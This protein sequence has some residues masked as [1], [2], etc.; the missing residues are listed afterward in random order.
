MIDAHLHLWR[1]DRGDYD[2]LRDEDPALRRDATLQEWT[3]LAAPLGVDGAVL[4]QAAPTAAETAYVLD[5]AASDPTRLLGVVGWCDLEAPRAAARIRDGEPSALVAL[6]P[7]LQAIDDPDWV[8]SPAVMSALA[9]MQERGL[10]WEAL[11]RPVH[12][13]RVLAVARRLPGLSIVV[14][15]GAKPDIAGGGSTGWAADLADLAACPNV[16][17]KVSGLLTEARPD[18]DREDLRPYVETILAAFGPTR[19]MWGSDWPVVTTRAGYQDWW[20]TAREL[21]PVAWHADVF[22]A[23]ARQAYGL[24][25]PTTGGRS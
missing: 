4:V 22:D 23:T 8:L 13:P 21:V 18:Q 2:W 3:D 10:V 25:V 16:Y 17:C 12:L 1:L 20:E 24:R 19:V 7:W 6:R 14:D 11:V 9:A 15:H 5:L